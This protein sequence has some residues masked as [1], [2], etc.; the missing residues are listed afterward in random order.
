MNLSFI[1]GTDDVAFACNEQPSA[2]AEVGE[3]IVN[4]I[5]MKAL[6]TFDQGALVAGVHPLGPGTNVLFG[7]ARRGRASQRRVRFSKACA[8]KQL[9][10]R[11]DRTW[12]GATSGAGD[13]WIDQDQPS[14]G[15]WTP[16]RGTNSD[17]GAHGVAE[18]GI[19]PYFQRRGERDQIGGAG[20]QRIIEMRSAFGKAAPPD[21]ST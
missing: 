8:M 14:Y 20:I 4:V 7:P 6:V 9:E 3:I 12:V 18:Q 5:V 11:P 2:D 17:P 10:K 21:A 15:R 13:R 16:A 1:F 19:R